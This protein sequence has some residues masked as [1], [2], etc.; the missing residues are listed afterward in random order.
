MVY[1]QSSCGPGVTVNPPG[2]RFYLG[3]SLID[4]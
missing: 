4:I 2:P 1:L 3:G